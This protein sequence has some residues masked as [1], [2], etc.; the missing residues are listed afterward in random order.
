[1][2]FDNP[3]QCVSISV[4]RMFTNFVSSCFILSVTLLLFCLTERIANDWSLNGAIF[5]PMQP[6]TSTNACPQL[7]FIQ[8]THSVPWTGWVHDHQLECKRGLGKP[9]AH[10]Q[11]LE[12]VH[13]KT[14]GN[15]A[16]LPFWST[17]SFYQ[18]KTN[19]WEKNYVCTRNRLGTIISSRIFRELFVFRQLIFQKNFSS[20]L[21]SVFL[22]IYFL[23]E[24][25]IEFAYL[26]ETF[27]SLKW[28]YNQNWST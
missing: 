17:M 3:F 10:S 19:S 15:N 9:V 21:D 8:Q 16:S 7:L 1:M 11:Y 13:F 25:P 5:S 28:A 23:A 27:C 26:A 4:P 20:S 18:W 2:R 22:T 14:A 6:C 24:L 12:S